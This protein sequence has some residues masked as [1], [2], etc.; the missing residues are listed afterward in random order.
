MC[1]AD[2]DNEQ[3][4]KFVVDSRHIDP[5]V[6]QNIHQFQDQ[7]ACHISS[8]LKIKKKKKTREITCKYSVTYTQ[9]RELN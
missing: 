6:D 4:I 3:Q 5:L 2:V 8:R 1:Y 7:K 9:F